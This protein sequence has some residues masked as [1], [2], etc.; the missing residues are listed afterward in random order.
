MRRHIWDARCL[1][2]EDN[3]LFPYGLVEFDVVANFGIFDGVQIR[4]AA[5]WYG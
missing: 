2:I 1:G 3:L 5:L 4:A